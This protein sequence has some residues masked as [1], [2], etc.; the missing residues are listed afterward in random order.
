MKDN[1]HTLVLGLLDIRG[2]ELIR[3]VYSITHLAPTITTMGGV[4]DSQK[5]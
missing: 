4:T 2:M 3:R 5:Y 1:N